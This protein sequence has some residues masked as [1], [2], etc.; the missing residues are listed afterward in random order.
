LHGE[1]ATALRFTLHANLA[2]VQQDN[3]AGDAQAKPGPVGGFVNAKKWLENV[4][5]M[6]WRDA[7]ARIGHHEDSPF[8]ILMDLNSDLAVFGRVIEGICHQVGDDLGEA[9]VIGMDG[10]RFL[11]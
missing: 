8:T 2:A 9:S 6:F 7:Y 5:K 4:R 11:R 3:L 10:D 1:T